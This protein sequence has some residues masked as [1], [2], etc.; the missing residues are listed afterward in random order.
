MGGVY[1]YIKKALLAGSGIGATSGTFPFRVYCVLVGSGYT[2]DYDAH[3][4]RSSVTNE[5]TGTL[6]LQGGFALSSPLVSQDNTNNYGVLTGS[7]IF[8]A[9]ETHSTVAVATVLYGSSGLG[10]AS[11][12]LLAYIELTGSGSV[13]AGTFQIQWQGSGGGILAIT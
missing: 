10:S 1:N 7:N 9:N 5:I 8:F 11:D 12:P 2:P 13:T 4:Y 6:Y 3:S